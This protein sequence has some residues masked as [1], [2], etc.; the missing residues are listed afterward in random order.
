MTKKNSNKVKVDNTKI[1]TKINRKIN[2]K[3]II[4]RTSPVKIAYYVQRMFENKMETKEIIL[5]ISDQ[6]GDTDVREFAKMYRYCFYS[7]IRRIANLIYTIPKKNI[8]MAMET[9][10]HDIMVKKEILSS[11]YIREHSLGQ[12]KKI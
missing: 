7:D 11:E 1:N 6:F 9:V 2:S 5:I 4:Q 10:V 12:P 3:C 8:D